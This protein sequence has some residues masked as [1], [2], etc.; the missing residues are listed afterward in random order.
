MVTLKD[1]I[2]LAGTVT[3][4]EVDLR[5]EDGKLIKHYDIGLDVHVTPHMRDE[6][7]KGIREVIEA[8]INKYGDAGKDGQS[9]SYFKPI[10]DSIPK[11]LLKA[12]VRTIGWIR[13]RYGF[14]RG[15]VLHCD[16]QTTQ[17]TLGE[18]L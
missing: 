9:I 1:L 2:D 5:H 8:R 10:Y 15:N 3:L 18:L 11:D 17:M 4:L 7:D 16:V 12:E 13:D 6:M 14:H